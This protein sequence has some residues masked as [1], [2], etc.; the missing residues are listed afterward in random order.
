[1]KL[2]DVMPDI[3]EADELAIHFK[4]YESEIEKLKGGDVYKV[5]CDDRVESTL[6]NFGLKSMSIIGSAISKVWQ[7]KHPGTFVE[8]ELDGLKVSL[9]RGIGIKLQ[10]LDTKHYNIPVTFTCTIM[11]VATRK[12]YIKS[13]DVRC[14]ICGAVEFIR[15]DDN[16]IFPTTKCSNRRCK[17]NVMEPVENTMVV[18][19]TQNV[20]L[21]E[22]LEDAKHN[23][24]T[25][26]TAKLRDYSVGEAFMGQKKKI[27]GVF[28]V[29]L[30]NS[31]NKQERDIYLDIISMEDVDDVKLCMPSPELVA[32]W[33]SDS[34]NPDFLEKVIHSYAPHIYGYRD[35]K[36]SILY[37]LVSTLKRQ[38]EKR[39]WINLFLVGDPGT[40]KSEMLRFASTVV[41]KSIY[42]TG[43]GSTG[44]GLTAGMVK[45]SDGT[46]ILSAGVYPLSHRGVVAVD[47]FDKMGRDDLGVMHEVMEQGTVSRAVTGRQGPVTLPAVC[48]TLAAANPKYGNYDAKKELIDN[49]DLPTPILSRFDMVWLI[50]DVVDE[51][52]DTHKAKYAL[53]AY[54]RQENIKEV[55]MS[56]EELGQYLNYCREIEPVLT[57]VAHAKLIKVYN[58]LRK[59]SSKGKT[60][61]IGMRQAEA[62]GRMAISHAK[63]L[64]KSQVD[65][66]D[67]DAVVTILKESFKSFG[68]DLETGIQT[69]LLP[70]KLSK[71]KEFIDVFDSQKN[72]IGDVSEADVEAILINKFGWTKSDV[73]H[74]LRQLR[75]SGQIYEHLNGIWRYA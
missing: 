11:A 54:K 18:G 55:Y 61:P 3:K 32:K 58:A 69:T 2:A 62:L 46:S 41:L 68:A 24:P 53:S 66:S 25:E 15:C 73:M 16:R 5:K 14:D 50:V 23:M 45:L 35:I 74:I 75:S 59:A 37:T 49:L 17:L 29:E 7:L 57:D 39:G 33:K 60:V 51:M 22:P 34:R 12:A 28:K 6:N 65:E 67:V 36:L 47:E 38:N 48:A 31:K 56:R 13:A 26:I 71:E 44:A 72:T 10:E 9:D 64:F 52:M 19:Y 1:M 42:T 27:T 21:Q 63:L 43:K 40:A 30:N 4:Q 20:I 8:V 70:K